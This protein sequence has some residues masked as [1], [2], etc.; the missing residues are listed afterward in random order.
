MAPKGIDA[1]LERIEAESGDS[2]RHSR[3]GRLSSVL[4]FRF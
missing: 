3:F 1:L 2:A 4:T